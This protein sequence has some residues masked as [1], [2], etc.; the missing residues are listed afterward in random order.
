[1]NAEAMTVVCGSSAPEVGSRVPL[2][3][4]L[5]DNGFGACHLM[6]GKEVV[7]SFS[8]FPSE[9]WSPTEFGPRRLSWVEKRVKT[10]ANVD[11]IMP[12]KWAVEIHWPFQSERW[13]RI[14]DGKWIVTKT[15]QGIA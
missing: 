10:W 13:E 15:G 3:R 8:A 1:M 4:T 5:H 7:A 11:A 6:R 2:N 12:V 14:S 9:R